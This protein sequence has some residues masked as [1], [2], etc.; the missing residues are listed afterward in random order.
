MFHGIN[1]D[2]LH[3]AIDLFWADYTELSNTNGSF[4][5]DEFIWK[6]KDIRYGNSNLWHQKYSLPCIKV[7]VLVVCIVT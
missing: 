1:E 5:S 6:S 2:E 3:F 7:L 4:D